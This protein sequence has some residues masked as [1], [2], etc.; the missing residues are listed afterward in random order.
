MW[1]DVR[2]AGGARRPR[3]PRYHEHRCSCGSAITRSLRARGG[4]VESGCCALDH[5]GS[6]DGRQRSDEP[7]CSERTCSSRS[8]VGRSLQRPCLDRFKGGSA[9]LPPA[10]ASAHAGRNFLGWHIRCGLRALVHEM[11]RTPIVLSPNRSLVVL[12]VLLLV[13]VAGIAAARELTGAWFS[14][15]APLYLPIENPAP[16]APAV[17]SSSAPIPTSHTAPGIQTGSSPIP[18]VQTAAPDPATPY[19]AS[20]TAAPHATVPVGPATTAAPSRGV[21]VIAPEP[22]SPSFSPPPGRE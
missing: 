2:T 7:S 18:A 8:D 5:A 3:S 16:L 4:P 19:V 21:P 12:V 9:G 20:P 22:G 17:D 15:V 10:V 1:N 13:A 11:L 6:A 14:P